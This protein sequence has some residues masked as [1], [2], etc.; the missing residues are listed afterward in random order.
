MRPGSNR[1]MPSYL[2]VAAWLVLVV[3]TFVTFFGAGAGGWRLALLGVV[4]LGVAA[5]LAVAARTAT[6][7]KAWIVGTARV[8]SVSDRPLAAILGRCELTLA[9]E[10]PGIPPLEVTHLDPQATTTKWPEVGGTLPVLVR[11]DNPR[12]VRVLWDRVPSD[13][14]SSR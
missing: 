3:A 12:R 9:V 4:L 7:P 13:Y 8:V 1:R 5:G 2:R 11:M 10:A 6:R 14:S